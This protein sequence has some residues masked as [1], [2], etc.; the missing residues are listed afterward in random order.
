MLNVHKHTMVIIHLMGRAESVISPMFRYGSAEMMTK[1]SA[2]AAA[3]EERSPGVNP[4]PWLFR[5]QESVGCGVRGGIIEQKGSSMRGWTM[6]A[7]G[8]AGARSQ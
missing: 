8:R 5:G 6:N 1:R 2:A 3:W 7:P 4:R